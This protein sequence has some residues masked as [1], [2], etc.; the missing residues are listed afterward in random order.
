METIKN[1]L[2]LKK[3]LKYYYYNKGNKLKKQINP[4]QLLFYFVHKGYSS[5]NRRTLSP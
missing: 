3:Y 5:M 2:T 4:T 1:N